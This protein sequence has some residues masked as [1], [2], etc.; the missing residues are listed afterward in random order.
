MA[1]GWGSVTRC[2]CL[3]LAC[4]ARRLGLHGRRLLLDLLEPDPCL[5]LRRYEMHHGVKITDE[6]LVDAAVESDRYIADR[7]LPDKV[8]LCSQ[9]ACMRVRRQNLPVLGR[10]MAPLIG[11]SCVRLG[12][13]HSPQPDLLTTPFQ[14]VTHQFV[15]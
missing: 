1:W 14:S 7:F 2:P 3:R 9:K 15:V 6:A 5:W 10:G 4:H 13:Q 8:C 12:S 11:R